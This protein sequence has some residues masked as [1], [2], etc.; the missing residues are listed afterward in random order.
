MGEN[1]EEMAAK[2]GYVLNKFEELN[3]S[4]IESPHWIE[5][6]DWTGSPHWTRLLGMDVELYIR[7]K[8]Y[9]KRKRGILCTTRLYDTD[10]LYLIITT[11]GK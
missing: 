11:I 3:D 1:K 9:K 6:P 2:K 4:W 8:C 5:S 7:H 10:L